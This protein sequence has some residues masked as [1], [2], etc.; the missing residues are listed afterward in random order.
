LTGGTLR[1]R[2]EKAL[3]EAGIRPR[4]RLGQNYVVDEGLISCI[5][6]T[7]CLTGNEAVLEIGAGTGNL[8]RQLAE[9]ARKVIAV[10]KDRVAARYLADRLSE[11]ANVEVIEGDILSMA[12]P[13]TDRVVSNLP[14]SIST[15]ITFKILKEGEFS[16]AVLTYQTEVAER[17]VALPGTPGYSRLSIMTALLAK[18][19]RIKSFPPESFYPKP[20][21]G[22]TVV[23]ME[24]SRT[25]GLDTESLEGTL[26]ALFSQRRR[27]LKKALGAYAKISGADRAM[28]TEAVPPDLLVKRVFEISPAEFLELDRCLRRAKGIV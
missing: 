13:K 1:G 11:R 17:L 28:A 2:T 14:Y 9:R 7:A 5:I 21:V 27:V 15:P 25:G 8:T 23:A 20:K 26:K 10:E 3:E 16:L 6:E 4:R 12:L 18:T 19:C 24:R 22:S